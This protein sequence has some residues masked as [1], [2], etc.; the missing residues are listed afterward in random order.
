MARSVMVTGGAGFIGAHCVERLLAAGWVIAYA[1]NVLRAADAL[2]TEAGAPDAECGLEMEIRAEP[3]HGPISL[4]G[5]GEEPS[6]DGGGRLAANNTS[7]VESRSNSARRS[8]DPSRG[9]D[10]T[11]ETLTPLERSK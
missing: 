9:L 1:V 5:W 4:L 6:A 2:R 10:S 7:A 8:I 11:V 3:E